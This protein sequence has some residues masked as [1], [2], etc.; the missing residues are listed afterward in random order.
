ML[1][2]GHRGAKNEAPEN[3]VESF[4]HAQNN[5]CLHFELDIQ[6]SLDLEL[7]VYHDPSLKRT[8]GIKGFIRD[9]DLDELSK[10]DARHNTPG[11][12]F[13]CYIPTLQSVVDSVPQT[14]SWQFEVK[15]DSK[16][17]VDDIVTKLL[18]FIR[19]NELK[20]KVTITSSS[21]YFL[22]EVRL[23]SD[24]DLGLVQEFPHMN[25]ASDA[26]KLSCKLLV[27]NQKLATPRR[28]Q[29]AIG[30]GLEVSCWTINSPERIIEFEKIGVASFITDEPSKTIRFFS[31]KY[32]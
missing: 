32:L 1:I 13:P 29:H 20:N 17:R 10:T 27:L 30:L 25:S 21:Q 4:V 22:K 31:K 24:I 28:V 9:F 7:I 16:E 5:G 15:P 23:K 6:L 2:I 14:L 11:W 12:E 3:T 18:E 26:A 19:V 8:C